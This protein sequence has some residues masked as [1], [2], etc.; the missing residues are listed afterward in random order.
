MPTHPNP[1]SGDN[2]FL[3]A[4]ITILAKNTKSKIDGRREIILTY[5]AICLTI[6]TS[7]LLVHGLLK[8]A[9]KSFYKHAYLSTGEELVFLGIALFFIYG[10]LVYQF[11]RVGYLKRLSNHRSPSGKELESIYGK[12]VPALT[13]LIPSYREEARIIKQAL[14]ST[15][16]QEYPNKRVV[17]LIDDPPNPS[18]A[19]DMAGLVAS[20]RL[21]HDVQKCV[22]EQK[23]R[24][25]SCMETFS[26]RRT[27]SFSALDECL[28]LAAC[29]RE[30]A[31]WFQWQALSF[32]ITDHTDRWFVKK[33]LLEPAAKYL[34]RAEE[35]TNSVEKSNIPAGF[36][37]QAVLREYR[38]LISLFDVELTSFERKKYINLSHEVNKAMNL[39][40]YIG[41]MGKSVREVAY[42]GHVH[43]EEIE[44]HWDS[45]AIP[46]TDYLITLDADSLL[47]PDYALRLIHVMEKP[48]NER[49]AVAQTPYNAVPGP[50]RVLE[51]IA[52]ATT[53]IQYIIHQGFTRYKA[54]FWVGANA[55][56]RK[57]AL[58][59]ICAVV[60]ER[61]F[62]IRRYIQDR[63][64]IEDTESS[65]D[66]I[67][68]DWKLFNYP[69]RLSY[70]AT[71]PDFGA[72]LIQRRRWANGGLI[73]LPK[74][75]GYLFRDAHLHRRLPEGL[76]RF[77]YL[78]SLA[79]VNIGLLLI[80]FYPFEP[81]GRTVLFLSLLFLVNCFVYGRDLVQ[82]GYRLTDLLRVY[83]LNLM[84]IP[85]NLGGVVKSL[86]QACTGQ[87][88]PF[89]RTPKVTGRT[90]APALYIMAEFGILTVSFVSCIINLIL[91]RWYYAVFALTNFLFFVYIVKQYMGLAESMEDVRSWW[92]TLSTTKDRQTIGQA[93]DSI[94]ERQVASL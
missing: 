33:V 38:K 28:R 94:L 3:H 48:G 92:K 79:G 4:M 60:N 10:N 24:L 80:L 83:A 67:E 21:P 31:V 66:L 69:D 72:L 8:I 71:P 58:E 45:I 5:A 73:I 35:L 36:D 25:R 62:K 86:H 54:T 40:S 81:D 13:M 6:A 16:L 20:R 23:I 15:A 11:M 30:V 17:L 46:D 64:V 74:L 93:E 41:L 87:K 85:I 55:L 14:L 29:H 9:I 61:G 78:V 39:N 51:R 90:A 63:T 82:S 47:M 88:I 49:L 91:A 68:R 42:K 57:V 27:T 77:H 2:E 44:P 76:A 89:G 52:G 34:K 50:A 43:L 1:F 12:M 70:S 75:L 7:L 53:D 59:D 26:E 56:L 19:H 65:V 18:D 84:L 32:E 22:N 37:E